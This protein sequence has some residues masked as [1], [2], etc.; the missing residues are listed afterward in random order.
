MKTT[1]KNKKILALTGLTLLLTTLKLSTGSFIP[2]GGPRSITEL[3]KELKAMP[4]AQEQIAAKTIVIKNDGINYQN[5]FIPRTDSK[6]L[7]VLNDLITM[8]LE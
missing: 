6:E 8:V 5:A 7:K 2:G 1:N 4:G 3:K